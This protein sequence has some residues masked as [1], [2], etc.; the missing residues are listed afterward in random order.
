MPSNLQL[1]KKERKPYQGFQGLYLPS[2]TTESA[3]A[4]AT[5]AL[6]EIKGKQMA[7]QVTTEMPAEIEVNKEPKETPGK[8]SSE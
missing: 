1:L 7:M 8:E 2:S 5:F 3:W 4:N 6:E